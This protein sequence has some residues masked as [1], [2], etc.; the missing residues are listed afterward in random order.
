MTFKKTRIAFSVVCGVLYLFLV[1]LWVRSQ[2]QVQVIS[3]HQFSVKAYRGVLQIGVFWKQPPAKPWVLIPVDQKVWPYWGWYSDKNMMVFNMPV[4]LV[5]AV[6]GIGT[7]A[8]WIRW[9][10]RFSLRT[11]LI[12]MT[13]V[14]IGLWFILWMVKR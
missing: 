2:S 13:A 9:S 8:P 3:S 6:S 10:K 12:A 11:L 14:A 1:S 4:L 5:A 7:V